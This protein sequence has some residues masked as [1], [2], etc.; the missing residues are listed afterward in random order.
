MEKTIKLHTYD[1]QKMIIL[2]ICAKAD[3]VVTSEDIERYTDILSE[4]NQMT[5]EE[6][7]FFLDVTIKS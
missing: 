4:L 1:I 2:M 5:N 3:G 6:H 7:D